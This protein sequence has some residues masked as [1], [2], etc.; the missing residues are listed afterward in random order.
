MKKSN[1]FLTGFTFVI[2]NFQFLT[3]N[4]SA[5]YN[6]LLDFVPPFWQGRYP[7]GS[8]ISDGTFLYG[9]TTNGGVNDSGTVFKIKPDGSG[10]GLLVQFIGSNGQWPYGSLISDG[11]FLYGMTSGGGTNGN[12][13]IFKIMPDGSGY[14]KLLDFVGINGS[15]PMGSLISDGTFLYGMTAHGGTSNKGTIFKILPDGTGYTKLLDFTGIA[16]GD[17]TYGSLFSDGTFLYGTTVMGGTN[18]SGVVFKI[19]PDGTGYTKML[20][21]DGATNGAYPSGSL[22]S[23]GSFLYGVTRRGGT[24]QN[25][26]IFKIKL[27]GTG[28]SVLH[29]FT[30]A[31]NGFFPVGDLIFT[32]SFLYGM[33]N[34]GGT[35]NNCFSGCGVI[36][37][38]KPDG[39]GY[40]KLLD[41]VGIANGSEPSGSLISDG[42]FLYGMT[43]TGGAAFCGSVF[44]LGITTGITDNSKP[45]NFNV[46]PNPNNGTFI[47]EISEP[48]KQTQPAISIYNILGERIYQTEIKNPK[49]EIDLS[50]NP[51]GIYFLNIKTEI[52]SSVQKLIL[53]K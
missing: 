16:N 46:Y 40:S 21:C 41:F 12:G 35:T 43:E 14:S 25:G 18:N 7:N 17:Y 11:T 1:L 47:I 9:M 19:K 24:S 26:N 29:E 6:K 8:L 51:A 48:F 33:T 13:V 31:T 50:T 20:D 36:Y 15:E 32:G 44:K 38:I 49:S 52:G 2:F 34:S 28:Y 23:D 22:I 10:Y 30:G 4:C 42:T 37:K 27:D 3:F 53:N 5:Q 45:N 39:T